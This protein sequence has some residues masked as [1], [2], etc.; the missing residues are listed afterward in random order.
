MQE[1][2]GGMWACVETAAGGVPGP[3]TAWGCSAG[4]TQVVLVGF[5][6][7][8]GQGGFGSPWLSSCRSGAGDSKVHR[9]AGR[10]LADVAARCVS[11]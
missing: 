5:A 8:R 4:A 7:H 10:A 6:G 3:N 2:Q 9:E 1:V 11:I